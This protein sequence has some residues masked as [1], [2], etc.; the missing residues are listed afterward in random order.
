MEAAK[1]APCPCGS[2]KKYKRCCGVEGAEAQ[3]SAVKTGVRKLPVAVAVA[4]V[5]IGLVLVFTHDYV[6]GGAVAIGGV[7]GAIM[8]SVFTDPPPPKAGSGDPAGLSFGR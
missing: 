4:G 6:T 8:L 3:T 5:V 1:N 7:V 2:G